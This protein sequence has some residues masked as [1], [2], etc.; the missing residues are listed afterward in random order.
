MTCTL[1]V[2]MGVPHFLWCDTLLIS[3][4]LLNCLASLPLSGKV[5]LRHLH[6]NLD[7]FV[8][9]PHVFGCVAFVHDY[10]PNTSKL[11]PSYIKGAFVSYSCTQKGYQV[12]FIDQYKYIISTNVTLSEF[13]HSFSSTSS[14][15]TPPPA[16]SPSL[17][18]TSSYS[19]SLMD[20]KSRQ[21]GH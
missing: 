5:P 6:P 1:L 18:P 7:I 16:L 17:I 10:T 20:E 12:Y 9:P 4:Y 14:S 2:E 15:S 21:R 8:F 19:S 3:I 13:T 11:A